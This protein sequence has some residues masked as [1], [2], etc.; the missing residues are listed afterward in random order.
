MADTRLCTVIATIRQLAPSADILPSLERGKN[1]RFL[2]RISYPEE[3]RFTLGKGEAYSRKG[4]Y[5]EKLVQK[6]RKLVRMRRR[7]VTSAPIKQD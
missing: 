2:F 6:S 7:R 1:V 4:S 5:A 3:R